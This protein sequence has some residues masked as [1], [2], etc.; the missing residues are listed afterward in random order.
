MFE[1]II[2]R[3]KRNPS[4]NKPIDLGFLAEALIFYQSVKIIA[5]K[6]I[7]KQLI[8]ECGHET[9]LELIE[10]EYLTI[11][12]LDN[13]LGIQTHNQNTPNERHDPIVYSLPKLALNV[14]S[15]ELFREYT[16]KS[17]KGRRISQ[18]FLRNVNALSLDPHELPDEVLIDFSD[19]NYVEQSIIHMIKNYAPEYPNPDSIKFQLRRDNK[20]LL[21]NT[22]ID[23]VT[24]NKFYHTRIP[25]IHSSLSPSYLLSH[26]YN[27]RGDIYFCNKFKSEIT[28]DPI[29]S[30]VFNIKYADL[31]QRQNIS[32][33]GLRL[34]QN[35]LFEDAKAVCE[36]INRGERTFKDLL[37]LISKAKKF[38]K[39]LAGKEPD[40]DLLREYYKEVTAGSW[41]DKLPAKAA[42]W[43]IFTGIGL[44]IDAL[45]GAGIGTAAGLAVSAGDALI[46]ESIIGGWKPN[47]FI[48]NE[49]MEFVKK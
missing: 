27:L 32:E 3:K 30:G 44:A 6:A 48:D 46:L 5:D 9:L 23:F 41:V 14:V 31:L 45:G 20:S 29:N 26:L 19:S 10:N 13:A 37:E 11:E 2:I 35:F 39:W 22:N 36:T 34:F 7:L 42:R 33:E 18:R 4:A 8:H 25:P 15:P 28:I 21:A 47:H 16:G 24:L 38:Q 1:S 49:L 43:S 17:G 40:C 12:Y